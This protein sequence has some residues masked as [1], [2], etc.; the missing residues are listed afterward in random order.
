MEEKWVSAVEALRDP[1]LYIDNRE[2]P[3]TWII[4]CNDP[5]SAFC[6]DVKRW[7]GAAHSPGIFA[8]NTFYKYRKLM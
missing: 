6:F 2:P 4:T 5:P 8:S 3:K 1:G 7:T